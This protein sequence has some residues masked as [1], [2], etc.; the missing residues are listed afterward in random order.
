MTYDQEA[1]I[2]PLRWLSRLALAMAIVLVLS[3]A[4]LAESVR[5][6]GSF[7][8]GTPESPGATVIVILDW[9][10]FV[11]M[12]LVL[13]RRMLDPTYTL[14]FAWAHGALAVLAI[15]GVAS[16]AWASDKY[17][18]LLSSGSLLSGAALLWTFS[19]VVRRWQHLRIIAGLCVGLLLAYVAHCMIWG[20]I[21]MPETQRMFRQNYETIFQQL[22]IQPGSF[23]AQ[24]YENRL[25]SAAFMG[26][27]TSP[28]I[29]AAAVVMLGLIA[30]ACLIQR[31]LDA[32]ELNPK[33]PEIGWA[34]IPGVA[35]VMSI[36]LLAHTGSKAGYAAMLIGVVLLVGWFL[37]RKHLARH[38]GF[39]FA[40]GSVLVLI[41]CC[42]L[43]A[44]GL[45]L[46]GLPE[47]SLNF[48]WRYW[49]GSWAMMTHAPTLGVG[50]SNFG[51]AY[52][53][54]RLPV[55][56]EGIKDPHN[57]VIRLV[58][59][60][61][62]IGATVG[63]AWAALLAYR[64]TRPLPVDVELPPPSG[65]IR[66]M[67]LLGIAVA[68]VIVSGASA[69]GFSGNADFLLLEWVKRCLM[70]LLLALGIGGVPI[71]SIKDQ[72]A[73]DRPAPWML[74]GM[75]IA[76]GL[77]F[78]LSLID[79]ALFSPGV[80]WMLMMI[81]GAVLG[82]RLHQDAIGKGGRSVV[83][84]TAVLLTVAWFAQLIAVVVPT[85]SAEL[86]EDASERL[87]SG[88]MPSPGLALEKITKAYET[89]PVQN[90][91]YALRAAQIVAT[92][93]DGFAEAMQWITRAI[94]AN[95]RSPKGYYTR[96]TFRARTPGNGD[97]G[98][99]MA[100]YE[101]AIELNPSDIDFRLDYAQQLI[102]LGQLD[103]AM[104]QLG[105]A[106]SII[107]AMDAGEPKRKIA[108][109]VLADLVRQ[110]PATQPR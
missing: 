86:K 45:Y 104:L 34:G 79:M 51:D 58:T 73:D 12:L 1:P 53:Q 38:H 82:V 101:K 43:M 103:Q 17:L 32:R 50:W 67:P 98:A 15:L 56:V 39:G 44:T 24:Q 13:V 35:A 78:V 109:P 2:S 21:E 88:P 59:E 77:L 28:N 29:F 47:D 85:I 19:Q 70:G 83:I 63:V 55:A 95:P 102:R 25:N 4:M 93:A 97:S 100:D 33:Q 94:E 30:L 75:I 40:V 22:N 52:Q 106:R 105:A 74:A 41:G 61:G 54:Y 81:A 9:L 69:V 46:G 84:V 87:L 92:R 65:S 10:A 37:L 42:A 90:A 91:D 71:L 18:A 3:R 89:A 64:L 7:D 107:G 49:V 20:M 36:Y 76:V 72:I 108:E 11:P 16:T 8:P 99:M 26:F 48:R 110:L 23:E 68:V 60:L 6:V 57:W 5:D 80:W 31:V 62:L 27:T 14:R 96:A 66:I